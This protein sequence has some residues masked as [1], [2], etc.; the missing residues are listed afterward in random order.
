MI[1]PGFVLRGL[2]FDVDDSV[3]IEYC[4]PNVDG[5]LTGVIVNHTI[6][7]DTGGQYD[8]EI[9]AVKDS[10]AALLLD[11]LEDLDSAPERTVD[12]FDEDDDDEDSEDSEDVEDEE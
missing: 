8:D 12:S 2:S 4:L 11:V 9:T 3:G 5:R 7:I 10:V 6:F 1:T